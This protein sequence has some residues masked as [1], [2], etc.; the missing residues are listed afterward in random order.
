MVYREARGYKETVA[1]Q[2]P[3]LDPAE[4]RATAAREM[5][6]PPLRF[7]LSEAAIALRHLAGHLLNSG[8]QYVIRESRN[9]FGYRAERVYTHQEVTRHLQKTWGTSVKQLACPEIPWC[10]RG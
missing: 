3:Q 4:T 1:N 6:K 10:N 5:C 7:L 8:H 9:E 2:F